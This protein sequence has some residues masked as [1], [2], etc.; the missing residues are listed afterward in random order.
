[1]PEPVSRPQPHTPPA[2]SGGGGGG[3]GGSG[4]GSP[5]FGPLR[6][7]EEIA[8][9]A[10]IAADL[11]V[12]F[13]IRGSVARFVL[14]EVDALHG[15]RSRSLFEFVPALSDIDLVV[16]NEVDGRR[17]RENIHAH[18][19][20]SRFFHWDMRTDANLSNYEGRRY[21]RFADE[22]VLCF[23]SRRAHGPCASGPT[24]RF[25][26][27]TVKWQP[28]TGRSPSPH[29]LWSI[30]SRTLSFRESMLLLLDVVYVARRSPHIGNR[31]EIAAIQAQRPSHFP[32]VARWIADHPRYRERLL[33]SLL[34]LAYA[35]L[36]GIETSSWVL[37]GLRGL[38]AANEDPLFDVAL[39]AIISPSSRTTL[40]TI[41]RPEEKR[42]E[43]VPLVHHVRRVDPLAV[44]AE[45]VGEV[46]SGAGSGGIGSPAFRMSVER[47]ATPGCCR[48]R[49]FARGLAEL[50][51]SNVK[52]P[53][54]SPGARSVVLDLSETGPSDFSVDSS[55]AAPAW[56]T[57]YRQVGSMRV[58]YNFL[59][60]MAG[61]RRPVTIV[62]LF[63]G[64][65][66]E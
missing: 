49:D 6:Q 21:V 32:A 65:D 26:A 9:L 48:Y 8:I 25:V 19:P 33:R 41:V 14:E 44:H 3:T 10:E 64:E 45:W 40:L 7:I 66:D 16:P 11:D 24:F 53:P 51:W 2:R 58:D 60:T 31:N 55:V 50:V 27:D 30:P 56:V 35:R 22:P 18:L 34:K 29:P 15:A 43:W 59:C 62:G 13:L 39:D 52:S 1:M 28:P 38:A 5:D 36:S 23:A 20:A 12:R 47:P 57:N 17:V 63:C 4:S 37:E 61:R 42:G 46:F 54:G